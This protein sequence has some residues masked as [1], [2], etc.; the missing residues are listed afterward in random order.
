MNLIYILL[1]SFMPL[2]P[3]NNGMTYTD[4]TEESDI[5]IVEG[6]TNVVY[7]FTETY[8][9]AP[10]YIMDA[11]SGSDDPSYVVTTTQITITVSD[12]LGRTGHISII[13]K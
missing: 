6:N 9:D 10:D 5:T 12:T 13:V 7:T 11:W 3:G 1:I 8:S 4:E 2:F